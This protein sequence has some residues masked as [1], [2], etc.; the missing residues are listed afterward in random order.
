MRFRILLVTFLVML[1]VASATVDATDLRGLV[2]GRNY[3]GGY[4]PLA[5]VPVALFLP[6]LN[7]TFV[8]V[9]QAATGPDGFY[10]FRGVPPGQYVIQIAGANYTVVVGYSAMQDLPIVYR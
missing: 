2:E 7:N 8:L 5:G 1:A 10:Y 3:A 9:S 4:G 6:Q